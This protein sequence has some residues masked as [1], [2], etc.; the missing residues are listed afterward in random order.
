[1]TITYL[2]NGLKLF[3]STES[4]TWVLDKKLARKFM[5]IEACKSVIS[6]L[7]QKIDRDKLG[8]ED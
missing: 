1:M 8:W 4:E 3:L 7:S 6:L 5:T 2:S